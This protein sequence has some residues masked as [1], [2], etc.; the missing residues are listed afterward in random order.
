[1]T[2]PEFIQ[3]LGSELG[4]SPAKLTDEALLASFAVWDSMGKMAVVAMFDTE[5]QH[6]IPPGVL[7]RCKTVED[8]V[9]IIECK[10]E[11]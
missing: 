11:P 8:L 2:K 7:Q 6:E 1:M 3:K 4:I 9:A 10:L 5:L